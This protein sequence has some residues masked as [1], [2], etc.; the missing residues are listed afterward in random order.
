MYIDQSFFYYY[1]YSVYF[2]PKLSIAVAPRHAY[3]KISSKAKTGRLTQVSILVS[4]WAF[5]LYRVWSIHYEQLCARNQS[6]NAVN[7]F[8]FCFSYMSL[9]FNVAVRLLFFP[10]FFVCCVLVYYSCNFSCHLSCSFVS[11]DALSF[12]L[13]CIVFDGL[14]AGSFDGISCIHTI[15]FSSQPSHSVNASNRLH[16]GRRHKSMTCS[17]PSFLRDR[18]NPCTGPFKHAC[19][20]LVI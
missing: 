15:H 13:C 18:M 7:M 20:P 5:F 17:N 11:C 6:W 2:Y 14:V 1:Y 10:F 9:K 19:H 3:I 8:Y 12:S 16:R 4:V